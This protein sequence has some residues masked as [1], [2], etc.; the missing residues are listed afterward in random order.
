MEKGTPAVTALHTIAIQPMVPHHP[1][2][3]QGANGER[4][5]P[6]RRGPK[7]EMGFVTLHDHFTKKDTERISAQWADVSIA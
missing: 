2:V 6:D 1:T 4:M 3:L 7:T 5:P